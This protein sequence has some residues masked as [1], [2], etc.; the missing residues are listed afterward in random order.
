MPIFRGSLPEE[1]GPFTKDLCYSKGLVLVCS[2]IRLAMHQGTLGRVPLLFC[3]KTTVGDLPTLAHLL[4]EGVVEPPRFLPPLFA[5]LPA[6]AAGMTRLPF[7]GERCGQ[8]T[9]ENQLRWL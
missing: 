4:A 3:G 5:D 8:D 6:L 7:L 2:F 9:E 1:C